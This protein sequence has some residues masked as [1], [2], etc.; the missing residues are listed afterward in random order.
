MSELYAGLDLHSGNTY[1]G[2]IEKG[3]MKR[4]FEKRVRNNLEEILGTATPSGSRMLPHIGYRL[5]SLAWSEGIDYIS[6]SL[7]ECLQ[8]KLTIYRRDQRSYR[9]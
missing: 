4:V 9:M 6:R 2:L 1:I 3:T 8:M 5:S 7:V